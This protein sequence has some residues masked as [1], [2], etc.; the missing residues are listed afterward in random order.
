MS[1]KWFKGFA[2]GAIPL[3]NQNRKTV[4]AANQKAGLRRE[5]PY[6]FFNFIRWS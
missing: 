6:H 2:R 1:V 3:V 5:T 4:L